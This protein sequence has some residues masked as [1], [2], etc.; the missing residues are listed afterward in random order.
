VMRAW[1]DIS[2]QAIRREDP[3]GVAASR[4]RVD[5]LIEREVSRGIQP[6]RIVLAG[7]SQGGAISLYTGLRHHRRL[8]GVMALSSYL[9]VADALAQEA[10]SANKD[11]PIF[12]GHGTG[13]PV[14]Q[15]PKALAS[16]KF[17]ESAGYRVEWHEY[18]MPHSVCIE[19]IRDIAVWLRRV[20]A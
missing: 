16:R 2:D 20:L 18:P 7:F 10:S 9:P 6:S 4:T 5:A 17:L 3:E 1:Y 13:D 12:M 19:E 15:Y 8:A 14:V 11:V